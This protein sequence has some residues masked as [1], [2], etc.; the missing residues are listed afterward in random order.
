MATSKNAAV[1]KALADLGLAP[2]LELSAEQEELLQRS[3]DPELQRLYDIEKLF[4]VEPKQ[5][6]E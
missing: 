2:Q 3:L 6:S 4:T 5:P 1:L